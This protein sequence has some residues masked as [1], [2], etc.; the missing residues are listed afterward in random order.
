MVIPDLTIM[1]ILYTVSELKDAIANSKAET[2]TV[3]FVPTM[4]ALHNGHVSLVKKCL[5]E[6][7][8]C[9]VSIFVNP[10]QF[11]NSEDL[12]KYPR[13]IE[14]DSKILDQAG[15]DLVFVPSVEEIYPQ[16]DTRQFD[17]GQLDKVMEG[18]F[19]PGHFNGV[20]QVVSRLFDIVNPD[21]AYFGEKDF[22]QLAIIQEMIR[23]CKLPVQIV[24]VPIMRES[25]GLAMSSRNQRL[26]E[27]QKIDASNIYKL[28][29]KS[30][31]LKANYSVKE[32]TDITIN[33]INEVDS[34]EVEYF[35][36]V[37][38]NTLQPISK[39]D[40]TSFAVGC[41]AVFCG[42]VRLI[43]NIIY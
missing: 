6:N 8:I 9:V 34:L 16:K 35:D 15:V 42:N 43:D 30:K 36:I 28:L 40:D 21:K 3:G 1:E 26:S 22:Q 38:G 2:K 23:Q 27:V 10:T 5:S 31:E 17:F 11:N 7:D 29:L 32:L 20:A 19:R 33:N 13:T 41:I 14:Q 25:S 12:Q 24:P 4:G 39:W 18:Q 37:D